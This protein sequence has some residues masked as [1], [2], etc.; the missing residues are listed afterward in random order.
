MDAEIDSLVLRG[1]FSVECAQTVK[2][3][4]IDFDMAWWKTKI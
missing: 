4:R 2:L 1:D 3:P